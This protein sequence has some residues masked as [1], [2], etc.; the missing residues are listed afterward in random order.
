MPKNKTTVKFFTEQNN[1][2]LEQK[3]KGPGHQKLPDWLVM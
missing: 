1:K 2:T 3:Q